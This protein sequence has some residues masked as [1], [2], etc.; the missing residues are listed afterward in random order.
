MKS[1]PQNKKVSEQRK[2]IAI[3]K[4]RGSERTSAAI[5]ADGLGDTCEK[6][7]VVSAA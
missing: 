5:A 6:R 1:R 2:E 4:V 7:S 3:A